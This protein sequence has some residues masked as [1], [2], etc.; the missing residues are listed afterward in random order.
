MVLLR[1]LRENLVVIMLC[2]DLLII[3]G[4]RNK[5]ACMAQQCPL[6]MVG[7]HCHGAVQNLKWEL[8][9]GLYP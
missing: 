1:E 7:A 3:T 9:I 5:V 6:I 2:C 4:K 8:Q